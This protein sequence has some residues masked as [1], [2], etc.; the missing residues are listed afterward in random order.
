MPKNLMPLSLIVGALLAP[1]C[2]GQPEATENAPTHESVELVNYTSDREGYLCVPE[3]DGPFGVAVYNHGGLGDALGGP[4]EGTCLALM[5]AG[6]IGFSPLRRETIPITG[7]LDDVLD[8]IDYA[9]SHPQ[10]D[11]T[12]LAILGFSRGGYLSFVGLTERPD[13]TVGVIM[14]PAPIKGLLDDALPG[15]SSI[16]ATALVLVAE[17]DLP[18]F[19]NEDEDHVA[20]A[21]AVRDA[22][23]NNGKT[24]ELQI[25]DAWA[26]NGHDL[27]QEVRDEY[28]LTVAAFLAANL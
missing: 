10:A 5:E 22:L 25:L 15:A 27:F 3:G 23:R 8:G 12:R 18:E 16:N 20:T 19:N 26:T 17:N 1:G 4:P 21:T 13:A 24:V 28:W 6:F 11:P 2:D 7:H 9:L 14:A